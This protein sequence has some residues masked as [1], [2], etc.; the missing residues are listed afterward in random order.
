METSHTDKKT[1]AAALIYG[2]EAHHIDH[3]VPL[4]FLLDIP[5][6]VTDEDILHS[7]KNFYPAFDI[8]YK[9]ANEIGH[10]LVQNF[11]VIF[12]CMPRDLFDEIFFF[13]QKLHGKRLH[14]IW[15]PHGNSD[16][17]HT[18][19]Y[20]EA[21][22]KE[23]VALVYG[24][25]MID[26]LKEKDAFR[27]LIRPIEM[28][29]I[30]LPFYKKHFL[31]FKE[32]LQKHSKKKLVGGAKTI[33][34]APTWQDYESSSS[35]FDATE[36]L[37]K[38]LPSTFQLIIKIHPN[39]LLG[40]SY[41]VQSLLWKYEEQDRVLFLTDFPPIY[42]ILDL[43]DIYVGDMSSI[44]YDFLSFDKPLYFF[45]QNGKNPQVDKGL[46]LFRCGRFLQREEY[47]NFYNMLLTHYEQDRSL[48]S[49]FRK[50]VYTYTFG[51]EK[52]SSLLKKEI[53]DS[54]NCFPEDDLNFF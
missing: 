53:E 6:F 24:G 13:S 45:N 19:Y 23:K 35:F 48:F 46:Y 36:L 21:L 52:D 37:I 47:A 38:N 43:V 44:G 2:P 8:R 54:Y 33:L 28:G 50:E 41:K 25:K 17:G 1:K 11:S 4:C 15:C 22:R 16:K 3:L 26:F 32:L 18:T 27:Q 12:S 30:R 9:N 49:D 39:L 29:N 14:T 34:Y 5:L 42:P 20:M 51:T 31:F 7:C 40:N 10:H